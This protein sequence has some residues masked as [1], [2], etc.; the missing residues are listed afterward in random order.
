LRLQ[1]F[2]DG[3]QPLVAIGG[4]SLGLRWVCQDATL[5]QELVSRL[6]ELSTHLQSGLSN[7]IKNLSEVLATCQNE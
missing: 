4:F 5:G 1:R 7:K 2:D 6:P 3:G